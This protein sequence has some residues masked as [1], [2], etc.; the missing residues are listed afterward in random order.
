[1]LAIRRATVVLP[2]PGLL[3]TSSVSSSATRRRK[4]KRYSSAPWAGSSSSTRPIICTVRKMR[5]ITGQEAIEILLQVMENQREDPV[6]VVLAGYR[7]RIESFFVS[8]PG[9]RS[10]IAHHIDFPDHDAGELLAIA[11]VLAAQSEYCLSPAARDA[12]ID[13]IARRRQQPNFANARSIR[14]ALDRVRLRQAMRFVR[15]Q[16]RGKPRGF[17]NHR[18]RRHTSKPR[19]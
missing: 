5:R 11:E 7:E 10:R 2:V 14:N 19:V 6:M 4:P 15:R 8:N 12:M 9:F 18:S 17:A 3:M 13:Y 16:R 1:M